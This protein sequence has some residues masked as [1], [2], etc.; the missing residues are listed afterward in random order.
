M[1]TLA[2]G[3]GLG[4]ALITSACGPTEADSPVAAGRWTGVGIQLMVT[5]QGASIEYDCAHGTIDQPLV[6]DRDGRFSVTGVH[7]REHG[8]PIRVDEP[9]DRHPARYDGRLA[10][11]SMRLTVTLI[12]LSQ[13]VGTF[14]LTF[15]GSGRIVKCL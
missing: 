5:A 11:N 2:L 10:E 9:S 15:G 13:S 8:G 4:L 12:D 14:D 1:R 3:I 7:V 6:A